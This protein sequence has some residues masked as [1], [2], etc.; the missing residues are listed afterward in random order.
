MYHRS[1]AAPVEGDTVLEFLVHDPHFPHSIAH[2]V[3]EV[4]HWLDVLPDRPDPQRACERVIDVLGARLPRAM[5]AVRLHEHM[6]R[7]QAALGAVHSAISATFFVTGHR[8]LASS[9]AG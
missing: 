5:P 6:D 4:R 7:I 1:T 9:D 2:S 8:A 3:A